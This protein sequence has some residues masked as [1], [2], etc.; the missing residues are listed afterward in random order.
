LLDMTNIEGITLYQGNVY[1]KDLF[2]DM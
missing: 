1:K 2:V